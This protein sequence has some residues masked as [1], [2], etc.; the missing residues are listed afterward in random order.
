MRQFIFVCRSFF[1]HYF[2][3]NFLNRNNILTLFDE[4]LPYSYQNIYSLEDKNPEISLLGS[5]RISLKSISWFQDVNTGYVW[6]KK[7]LSAYIQYGK[8]DG[9]DI[10]VPWELS[11]CYFLPQ[12]AAAYCKNND[13]YYAKECITILDNWIQENP[14]YFGPN[15]MNAMEVGIRISNWCVTFQL[16]L[17]YFKEYKVTESTFLKQF[18]ASCWQHGDYIFHNLEKGTVI[19]NHYLADIVGLLYIGVSFPEFKESKKWLTCAIEGLEECMKKQVYE[20]GVDFESSIS[21]HRLVTEMFGCAALVCKYAKIQLSESY[22][23]KLQKMFHFVWH[24]TKPNGQAPQIGDNDNGRLHIFEKEINSKIINDHSHLFVLAEKIWPQKIWPEKKSILFSKGQIAILRSKNIYCAIS[25]RPNGQNGNGG[26]C[27]N[28][29]GSFELNAYG[30]D[31]FIDP[32]TY[33]YTADLD[34]RNLFRSTKMHN[35]VMVDSEEQNRIP[36]KEQGVFWMYED[37]KPKI[38]KWETDKLKDVLGVEHYGYNRLQNQIT[39]KRLFRFYKSREI[40]EIND[41]FLGT[42]DHKFEWN[43]YLHPSIHIQSED[44]K[45][46]LTNEDKTLIFE[47]PESLVYTISET[48]VSPSYGIKIQSKKIIFLFYGNATDTSFFFRIYSNLL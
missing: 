10:K 33:T 5:N 39:H 20:D 3:I 4:R 2:T 31:F 11:R 22:L 42:G 34:S 45:I 48:S 47:F 28:D 15:W 16:L 30:K 44:R 32:G 25:G 40:L 9:N 24:Y 46:F 13:T 43:F 1:F 26:H 29:I 36:P 37:A 38:T 19:S 41:L 27:H 8:G 35:T 23:G 17:P 14:P 21:Y 18:Y 6:N 12:M 7:M